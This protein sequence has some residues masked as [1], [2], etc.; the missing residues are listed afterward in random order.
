MP[1]ESSKSESGKAILIVLDGVGIGELPDAAQY[2]DQGSNTLAHVA[3]SVGGLN[4]PNL[5]KLGLGNIA[6]IRGVVPVAIPRASHGKMIEISKGKDSTVGHW[7]LA[8]L[9]SEKALPVYAH[10]FPK[11]LVARFLEVTGCKGVLGN[12]TASGTTIIQELGEEHLKTGYPIVYT[13]ADSVFQI[14][15][16]EERIPLNDLYD[17]CRGTRNQ[18]C[19]G[20]HAVGRVIARPFIGTAG[21]FIRTAN[22]HDFSLLPPGTTIL[23]ALSE[24]GIETITIG[25]VDDLFAGRGIH[26]AIHTKN[27]HDGIGQIIQC[28]GQKTRGFIFVNLVDFDSLYGHR[29]DPKGFAQALETFDRALPEIMATLGPN[30][31]LIITADHGNDPTTP[32]TDHSREHVPVLS[33]QNA[34]QSGTG[35]GIRSTFADA[36]KSI[37]QFFRIANS[38]PG[39]SF[40]QK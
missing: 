3:E 28:S 5:S 7:E 6:P 38:F 15:A 19:V 26:T 24:A 31:L 35:L 1:V 17:I 14:A 37:L 12:R 33:L 20:E 13:S 9:V 18:V 40:L 39:K 34:T 22:R 8:G 32:S 16:H 10:G 4:L 27:N 30:D 21:K 11:E 29:N 25:K 36:G 23:D 2:G